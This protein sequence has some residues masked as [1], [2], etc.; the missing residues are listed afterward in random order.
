[1]A[2]ANGDGLD[3]VG[4][5]KDM[6]TMELMENGDGDALHVAL[7]LCGAMTK[8]TTERLVG[9]DVTESL[10]AP[11]IRGREGSHF[12]AGNHFMDLLDLHS[13]FNPIQP[14][15]PPSS[16][17]LRTWPSLPYPMAPQPGNPILSM[18]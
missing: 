4:L 18:L 6:D 12:L 8:T 16:T 14:W 15:P 1:M 9:C 5:R 13:T 3:G 11:K 7:V 10:S 17:S 2:T